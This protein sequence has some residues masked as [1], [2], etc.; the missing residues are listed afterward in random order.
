MFAFRQAR[1]NIK[2]AFGPSQRGVALYR[3][4]IGEGY[5]IDEQSSSL[6]TV[7]LVKQA[8]Q[9]TALILGRQAHPEANFCSMGKH[10]ILER[11]PIVA[12]L[13]SAL[14]EHSLDSALDHHGVLFDR[15][16][17]DKIEVIGIDEAWLSPQGIIESSSGV[18]SL[19]AIFRAVLDA[20]SNRSHKGYPWPETIERDLRVVLDASSLDQ[21]D[22]RRPVHGQAKG[23]T[24]EG[25]GPAAEMVI[26]VPRAM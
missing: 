6:T 1:G 26:L 21:V 17:V 24:E 11:L 18:V 25:V 16:W 23:A 4:P 22:L 5:P 19:N 9:K 20:M 14:Q 3:I 15:F 7:L 2:I 12:P 10:S 8:S 13:E